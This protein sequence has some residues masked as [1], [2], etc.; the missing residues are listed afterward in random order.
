MKNCRSTQGRKD[1]LDMSRQHR[2]CSC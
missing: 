1:T 2:W